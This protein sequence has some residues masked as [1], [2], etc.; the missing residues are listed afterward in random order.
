VT[1]QSV[2]SL[3]PERDTQVVY[4]PWDAYLQWLSG[5][6]R[7]AGTSWGETV[8]LGSPLAPGQHMALIG[9]TGCAKTTHAVGVLDTCR[10]YVMALDPKGE[11]E[12]LTSSGYVR[13]KELPRR[14]WRGL[15]G[16]DQ[17]TWRQIQKRI[18]NGQDARVLIGGGSRT[19]D[20][21]V[22]LQHLMRDAVT[23]SRHS[24][25]WTLYIDEFELLSSQRMFKLGPLIERMLITARRDRTSVITTFQAPAWVSKHATRQARYAVIWPQDADM[26]RNI[27]R[28]MSR[29]WRGV[30]EAVDE[31]PEWHTLTIPRGKLSGPM[32]ITSAPRLGK[33]QPRGTRQAPRG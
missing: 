7:T 27:A 24:G 3:P 16:E 6:L 5:K 33:P 11:D 10:K 26:I 31:L 14:G 29:N 12:T 4:L 22:A 30:A 9:P 18:D 13:V 25:G 23:Y 2:A 20:Q 19:D 8:K 15:L 32:I 28:G 1:L 17:K 21:D